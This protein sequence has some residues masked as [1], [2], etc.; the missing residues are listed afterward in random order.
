MDDARPQGRPQHGSTTGHEPNI[1]QVRGLLVFAAALLGVTIL[2]QVILA[3]VMQGFSSEEKELDSLAVPRFAG[4]TG[5][6]PSPR[7]QPDPAEEFTKMKIEDLGRLNQ[8]GWIDRAAGVAHIP[9]DRAVDILAER[10]LPIPAA[11]A[12][13]PST[14]E[15]STS[16][17]PE[18][19]SVKPG[20]AREEKP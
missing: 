11:D 1:L 15:K 16:S 7:I 9:V 14:S 6:F 13:A 5:G 19:E 4:D 3:V 10:G 20:R 18:K 8:Y 12:P 17:S 2:V